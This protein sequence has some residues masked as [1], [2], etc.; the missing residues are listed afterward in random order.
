MIL[1][2]STPVQSLKGDNM[3]KENIC[4]HNKEVSCGKHRC[5]NCE[6]NPKVA[7]ERLKHIVRMVCRKKV[8]E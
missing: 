4:I 3:E 5:D 7:E 2:S 6:W 8:E 1:I